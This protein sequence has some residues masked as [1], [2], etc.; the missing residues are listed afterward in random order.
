M[1]T[2][3]SPPRILPDLVCFSH[4]RWDFVYQRPQHLMSRFARERR[5]FFIEEP[6]FE[7]VAAGT[8]RVERRKEGV[9]VVVPVLPDGLSAREAI[10]AQETL[11]A[12][13]LD[14][15]CDRP[16]FW[17]QT[18]MAVSF[19]PIDRAGVVI[20]D[21][22]D[23][24]S[25]FKDAPPAL[26][27]NEKQL[28]GTADLVFTGGRALYEAKR[29]KHRSVHCFPSGI[30]TKHFGR[31]RDHRRS[32]LRSI[33]RGGDSAPRAGFAGVVDERMDVELLDAVAALLPHV[34]F[35]I[36]GPVVK[37]DP[38]LLPQRE[39]IHYL[40]MQDY[41][42]L[43]ELMA[44]WDVAIMPFACNEATRFISPTKTPEYLAAGLP[45]VSTGIRDVVARYGEPGL[46]SIAD[47]AA[48]FARALE[49]A[50]PMRDDASRLRAVDVALKDS[51]W[52]GTWQR[53]A[54]LERQ[55]LKLAT[56]SKQAAE[57]Q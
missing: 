43:P 20:Y 52:E 14:A 18:P 19:A 34:R 27:F 38:A 6:V 49:A 47:E 41:A 56:H 57:A 53:M 55:V 24:L 12:D 44:Q 54:A 5:V 26:A 35:D 31:A 45:V 8:L 28:L 33:Q 37:I 16:T 39:N 17:F 25:S 42:V 32:A 22:M 1:N 30:D 46:V 15:R 23:E 2:P 7:P 36:I 10:L 29:G 48:S 40:G 13:F 11:I 21:C 50:I 4:L 9:D 51:S 3:P